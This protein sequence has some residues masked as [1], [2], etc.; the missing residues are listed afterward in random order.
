MN[1]P[2]LHDACLEQV[3]VVAREQA[4]RLPPAGLELLADTI[5]P[6]AGQT[7]AKDAGATI[8]D[9]IRTIAVNYY[10]DGP[11]VQ[12]MCTPHSHEGDE[13][14]G[15]WSEAF[16]RWTRGKVGRGIQLDDVEDLAQ[17]TFERAQKALPNFRF[18]CR[19]STFFHGIFINSYR[20]WIDRDRR[21]HSKDRPIVDDYPQL[22]YEQEWPEERVEAN[23]LTQVR[24]QIAE[25]IKAEDY[26]ILNLYYGQQTYTDQTTGQEEKWTDRAIG[27][28][29]GRPIDTITAKR[30]RALA[31][32]EK[33]PRMRQLFRDLL[34]FGT[35]DPD[36]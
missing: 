36:N 25:I 21:K 12:L 20:K 33:D 19:L 10:S 11:Q 7:L 17:E 27:E 15:A 6:L 4:W 8:P 18:Q 16:V 14:W 26:Q 23:W 28:K 5:L 35:V 32:L 24:S 1:Y 13:Y 22:L 3:Q 2:S 34:G 9:T 31:R 30:R 29:L